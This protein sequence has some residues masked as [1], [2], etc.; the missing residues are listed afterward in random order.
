METVDINQS[1]SRLRS[2]DSCGIVSSI[3]LIKP[4]GSLASLRLWEN[5]VAI[6]LIDSIS[7]TSIRHVTKQSVR[8]Y[9]G[10]DYQG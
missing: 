8:S 10:L 2:Y 5:P 1:L 3:I 7:L 6:I 4:E 9:S